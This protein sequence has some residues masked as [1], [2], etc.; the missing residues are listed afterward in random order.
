MQQGRYAEA[1]FQFEEALRFNPDN[2]E[3]RKNIEMILERQ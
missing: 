3:A 2:A 1:L